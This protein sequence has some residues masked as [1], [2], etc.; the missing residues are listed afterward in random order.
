MNTDTQPAQAMDRIRTVGEL[1]TAL[2]CVPDDTPLLVNAEDTQDPEFL[3][4]Q[5]IES[6]GFGRVD[7]GDGYGLEQDAFFGLNCRTASWTEISEIRNRPNR[8]NRRIA[9]AGR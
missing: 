9:G 3:D 2:E 6:A 1:R 4:E 5:F 8:P 7:W